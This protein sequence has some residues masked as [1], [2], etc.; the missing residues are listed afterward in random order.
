MKADIILQKGSILAYPDTLNTA[1]IGAQYVVEGIGYDFIPDVLS[2][3]VKDINVWLKSS[4]E[5]SFK[6]VQL[7]MRNEGLLVGGSCGTALAGALRWL[8]S[9]SGKA[10]ADTEGAN[11]V[12]IFADGYATFF[13]A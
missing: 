11:V 5:E 6:A 2:R 13:M 4:D 3:D 1:D 8:Q 10:I 12:V 7:I 9:D